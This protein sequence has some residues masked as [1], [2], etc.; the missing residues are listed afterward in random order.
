M[1]S[2]I[3]GFSNPEHRND[4]KQFNT[5]TPHF[6]TTEVTVFLRV[7]C[8]MYRNKPEFPVA[9]CALGRHSGLSSGGSLW[10]GRDL[11]VQSLHALLVSAWVVSKY[12]GFLPQ[13]KDMQRDR[14]IDDSKLP[15]GMNASVSGC[16]SLCV[17][18]A[19]DL[20]TCPGCA[21]PLA[22]CQLG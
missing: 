11:S 5:L 12:S 7:C 9:A 15:V 10:Q 22:Q 19:G 2:G 13:S 18:P 16:L 1:K 20:V 3:L 8:Y 21:P 17:S 6:S 4:E 14:L